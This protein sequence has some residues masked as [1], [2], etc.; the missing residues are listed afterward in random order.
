MRKL[1][2]VLSVLLLSCSL[3]AQI[4]TGNIFCKIVDTEGNPLPGV[5]VILTGTLTAPMT[6]ITSAEG[7]LRFLSLS[8]A[9]DYCIKTELEGFKSSLRENI[10]V[11]VGSN[12][13]LTLTMEMGALEEE[14]TVTAATP[15]VD[16]RKTTIGANITHEILQGLPT[17]RDPWV[18]LQMAPSVVVDRE[19]VGGSESGQ[20]SATVGRG[21]SHERNVWNMDGI[22]LNDPAAVG[23]NS[24]YFDFDM[25]EE[26]TIITGGGDV[27]MQTGGVGINMVTKRGGNKMSF[28]G[29]FYL[30]DNNFQAD[31][32]TDELK[33]EG[34]VG[35]N[36]THEIK[37]YGFN[38]GGP[39][40]KE[41]AWFWGAWGVQDVQTVTA[42]GNRDDTL[43]STLTGK[44][45]LQIIPENRLE[46][47]VY[48][49]KKYKYGRDANPSN[50]E[51]RIQR[52]VYHFGFPTVKIQDE[53]MFGDD[54][55][56]SFK[57]GYS[58]AAFEL[59]SV[60]DPDFEN[61]GIW[62]MQ[63][64]RWY[65]SSGRGWNKRPV[66]MYNFLGN[67][68]NET[69]LGASHDVKVG[70]EYQERGTVSI[71]SQPGNIIL[72]RNY[73]SPTV[74]FDGDGFP[75][76][77]VD[78]NFMRFEFQ[79][80]SFS[81]RGVTAL[82]GY[83]S[84]TISFGRFNLMLGL[85]YDRQ[86]PASEA[87]TRK[88]V[89]RDNPVWADN[90]T[91][92]TTDLLDQLL[93]GVDVPE[94]KSTAVDGSAYNWAVFSP[95]LGLTWAVTSD[96]KTIAK[97]SFAQY[98]DYMGTG[99]ASRWTPGGSSGWLQF[100]WMDNGDAIVDYRELYWNQLSNYSPYRVFDD[101]GNFS[102]NWEDA[103]D[104]FWGSYDYM[105]PGK[106]NLVPYGS[107][108]SNAGSSRTTEFLFSLEREIFTDFALQINAQY[109]RYDNYRWTLKSFPDTGVLENQGWY[110]S[111]GTPPANIPGL[112]D[113]KE[114]QNNE[115]Y[116]TSVEGTNYSPWTVT[117]QQP[118]FYHD[119]YGLDFIF[120]KRLSK[121]WMFNGNFT[122]QKQAVHYGDNGYMNPTNLWALEGKEYQP[123]Q[124]YGGQIFSRWLLK[125]GGLY[126]LPYDVNLSFTFQGREGWINIETFQIVDY[127]LPNPKSR[128]AT[129]HMT[130][131]GTERL[132][133]FFN[134][135]FRVEKMVRIGD[136]GKIYLMADVFNALNS[137]TATN[138]NDRF[139][140]TF[141]NY[142]DSS[143]NTFVPDPH[144]YRLNKILNPR[145][146][147][148]GLRF[149][150]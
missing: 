111:A 133:L 55:F 41:K 76:I 125:L 63:D 140:G 25:F 120:I 49:N 84:D 139:Q 14:V 138:R 114:A 45:N 23:S 117:K 89:D 113:S 32:L 68:F 80:E 50:P 132:P 103:A 61:I 64:Q 7:T 66:S 11:V 127:T 90:V 4:R 75:D 79:R 109:R 2:I 101:A 24:P 142:E 102:G 53:H 93:P 19:N 74:D 37:D 141:Y 40:V 107:I 148:L 92:Q 67:Y 17:A 145:V 35:V 100:W 124:G 144:T 86:T 134:L 149:T 85:R 51:G 83:L 128:S 73:V 16:A 99:E 5:T 48:G 15:V 36:K 104:T 123:Y 116:Y 57:Y 26:M 39:L 97:L 115:W 94:V 52:S 122:L 8:P 136:N 70:L 81:S 29:R 98:G 69:L 95:R 10:I 137:A 118:D 21:G 147:R 78:P 59:T 44:I 31:N 42:Y 91:S 9:K 150:F 1:L 28:G 129:L 47:F 34:V 106:L 112:G 126:Q 54:L 108:D 135:S 3:M 12:V 22:S 96:G 71:S 46:V 30:T 87:Y 88:A 20:S 6:A 18:V 58:N 60:M 33:A 43:L 110:I 72:R 105:N 130:P 13:D 62:D 143:L 121:G 65:S 82:V 27:S 77:P 146:M 131:R 56:V 119:Y 38:L